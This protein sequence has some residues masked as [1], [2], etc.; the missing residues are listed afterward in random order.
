MALFVDFQLLPF[1]AFGGVVHLSE[2]AVGRA[3]HRLVEVGKLD[4]SLRL[5]YPA[6]RWLVAPEAITDLASS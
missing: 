4:G 6:L 5:L 3:H 1:A 2:V